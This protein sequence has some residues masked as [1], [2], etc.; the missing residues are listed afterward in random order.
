MQLVSESEQESTGC[1]YGIFFCPRN[2]LTKE[3]LVAKTTTYLADNS[4]LCTHTLFSFYLYLSLSLSLSL[5]FS[6]S[7][8]S[9]SLSLSLSL[10]LCLSLF[11]SLSLSLSLFLSPSLKITLSLTS[12]LASLDLQAT[13]KLCALTCF[14]L[15]L[16]LVTLF[17]SLHSQ[18]SFMVHHI[19]SCLHG[20]LIFRYFVSVASSQ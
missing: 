7:D 4:L 2:P 10:S 17:L 19:S 13:R 8:L 6:L 16:L 20:Q 14:V 18:V 5:C 9:I 15:C 12:F 11:L 3:S 1:W